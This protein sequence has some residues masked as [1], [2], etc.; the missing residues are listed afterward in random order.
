[1]QWTKSRIANWLLLSL[2]IAGIF[3]VISFV[4]WGVSSESWT[5]DQPITTAMG[6]WLI[7]VLISWPYFGIALITG[8]VLKVVSSRETGR[9]Y[10]E[11]RQY[12]ELHDWLQISDTAWRSFKRNHTTFTVNQLYGANTYVLTVDVD[13]DSVT[14]DGFSRSIYALQ[15]GDYLWERVLSAQRQ[16]SASTVHQTRQ[17]WERFRALPSG[18]YRTT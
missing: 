1:M 16:A 5:E 9:I 6:L 3:G 15:F 11:S 12:A 7:L 8:V 2:P 13:G 4:G 17:E 14:T 18:D 10:K